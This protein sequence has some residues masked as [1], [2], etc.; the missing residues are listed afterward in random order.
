MTSNKPIGTLGSVV[1]FLEVIPYQ[2]NLD[3]NPKLWNFGSTERYILHM[4]EC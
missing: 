3:R 2:G 4:Q 1:S